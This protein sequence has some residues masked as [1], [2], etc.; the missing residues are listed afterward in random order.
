MKL[1]NKNTSKSPSSII[2]YVVASIVAL[3]GIATLVN[4]I[5]LF[6]NNVNQY[7]SQGYPS[8]EVLKQLIPMQLL[9]GVFEPIAVYEGI[10]FVLFGL[11]I[12]IKKVVKHQNLLSN[13]ETF[14]E[15]DSEAIEKHDVEPVEGIKTV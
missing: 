4:N 9:P 5:L 8:S 6:S 2:L 3:V 14:S 7:V 15:T 10:A 12:L 1:K 13:S 11:G